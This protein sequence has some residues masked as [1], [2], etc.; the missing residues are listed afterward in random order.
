MRERPTVIY[1]KNQRAQRTNRNILLKT[2]VY[3]NICKHKATPKNDIVNPFAV[4]I[5]GNEEAS[6]FSNQLEYVCGAGRSLKKRNLIAL[7]RSRLKKI[8]KTSIN[9]SPNHDVVNKN[10]YS[11]GVIF[12]SNAELLC[13]KLYALWI[14]QIPKISSYPCTKKIWNSAYTIMTPIINGNWPRSVIFSRKNLCRLHIL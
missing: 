8:A 14:H 13:K 4:W 7:P 6:I 9:V 1:T 5:L 10:G 11:H 12:Q 2:N 3:W